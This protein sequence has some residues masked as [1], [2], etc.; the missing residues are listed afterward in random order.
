MRAT[1]RNAPTRAGV[2]APQSD[3]TSA[4][5]NDK[6]SDNGTHSKPCHIC[7]AGRPCCDWNGLE[8]DPTP[9]LHAIRKAC[10]YAQLELSP[11]QSYDAH[12]MPSADHIILVRLIQWR[13]GVEL[14]ARIDLHTMS[15]QWVDGIHDPLA[16][17][18]AQAGIDVMPEVA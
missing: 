5:A 10:E 14:A 13:A 3:A 4:N 17:E 12:P 16:D 2:D 7:D 6:Y 1:K 9:G 18:L 15:M 8:P 11:A